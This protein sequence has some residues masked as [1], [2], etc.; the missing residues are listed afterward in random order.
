[1][2][3]HPAIKPAE[4]SIRGRD[5]ILVLKR[6]SCEDENPSARPAEPESR[7]VIDGP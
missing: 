2:G 6:A 3:L 7:I 1:M 5:S 4:P